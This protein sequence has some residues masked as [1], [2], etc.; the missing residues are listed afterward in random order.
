M[1]FKCS[2]NFQPISDKK[3]GSSG[4]LKK[5]LVILFLKFFVIFQGCELYADTRFYADSTLKFTKI[6]HFKIIR[7]P[8]YIFIKR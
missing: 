7:T 5:K 8:V 3:Y 6:T 1:S 2:M 4:F